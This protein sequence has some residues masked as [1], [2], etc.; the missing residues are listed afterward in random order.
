M[1]S[2]LFAILVFLFSSK[3]DLPKERYQQFS[4]TKEITTDSTEHSVFLDNPTA[5]PLR[6]RSNSRETESSVDFRFILSAF[7]DTTL[8]FSKPEYDS[9]TIY[10]LK[11]SISL[12]NHFNSEPDTSYRYRWPFPKGKSYKVMQAYYG[13]Y[14]HNTDYSKYAIDFRMEEGDTITA[15]RDGIVVGVIED[16]NVGGRNKKYRDFAN[17]ITL[18]H[19]DGTMSQYAHI[20]YKG[21]LVEVGDTVQSLQ[22]IG[23]AGN[24]GFSSVPHLHFNTIRATSW[25]TTVGFPI[26]FE[27]KR[28]T[29]LKKGMVIT[30]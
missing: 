27:T 6:V 29:E 18:I 20:M 13:S 7:S 1:R 9:S 24:T 28:G 12:G 17:Y 11:F 8:T 26:Q 10:D 22:P 25:T 16:Y 3:C 4:I 21:A 23:L 30:H 14:S 19:A 5:A 15:A 2:L